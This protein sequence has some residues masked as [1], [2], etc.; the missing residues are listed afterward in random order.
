LA[1]AVAALEEEKRGLQAASDI[2]QTLAGQLTEVA[3][4]LA[5]NERQLEERRDRRSRTAQKQSD[6]A[7]LRAQTVAL[8]DDAAPEH[9]HHF[10]HLET[11]RGEALGDHQLSVES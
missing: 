9:A 8:L 3:E 4:A 1:V 6:A 2:L 10:A 7:A 5:E 11:L